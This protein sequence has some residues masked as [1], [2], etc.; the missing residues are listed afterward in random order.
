ME[1]YEEI[2]EEEQ[3]EIAPEEEN[4]YNVTKEG[5]KLR[6]RYYELGGD[7]D[8]EKSKTLKELCD[9]YNHI[10]QEVI[11]STPKEELENF[12]KDLENYYQNR[13]T[14][15]IITNEYYNDCEGEAIKEL[16]A[17]IKEELLNKENKKLR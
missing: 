5:L 8:K 15:S 6:T 9:E 1:E 14:E 17:E 3:T 4:I 12:F 11:E 7:F 10:K 13:N 16:I 2:V